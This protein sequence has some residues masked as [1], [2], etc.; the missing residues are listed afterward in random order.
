MQWIVPLFVPFA[1][2]ARYGRQEVPAVLHCADVHLVACQGQIVLALRQLVIHLL[3]HLQLRHMQTQ[4]SCIH[5]LLYSLLCSG[6]LVTTNR[7]LQHLQPLGVLSCVTVHRFTWT[8]T[9]EG[10]GHTVTLV[11]FVA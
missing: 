7:V 9:L 6:Q 4:F 8:F 10:S 11:M 2:Q 3:Q 5:D 1:A